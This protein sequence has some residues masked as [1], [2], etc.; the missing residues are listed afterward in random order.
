MKLVHATTGQIHFFPDP[1]NVRYVFFSHAW[2][3]PRDNEWPCYDSN[4]ALE[5]T[6]ISPSPSIVRNVLKLA[7]KHGFD[8]AWIDSLCIDKT[9]SAEISETIVSLS[10]YLENSDYC[11]A[12][13]AD[14]TASSVSPNV[15][16]LSRCKYWTRSW[17]LQ[18]MVV[19]SRVL[20]FD[21]QFQCIG[22][23]SSSQF[24]GL[25]SSITG[26]DEDVLCGRR[27]LQ[28]I[29]IARRMSWAAGRESSR[30]EDTI[31]ALLGLFDVLMPVMYGEGDT[32]AIRRLQQ[33][34]VKS[35]NDMSLLA[36]SSSEKGEFRGVFASS[37][38]EYH[39]FGTRDI[40]KFPFKFPG[41]VALTNCGLLAQGMM[42]PIDGGLFLNLGAQLG[43]E[44]QGRVIGLLLQQ[45]TDGKFMR[46]SDWMIKKLPMDQKLQP[47]QIMISCEEPATAATRVPHSKRLSNTSSMHHD[48]LNRGV[49]QQSRFP[50]L[51]AKGASESDILDVEMLIRQEQSIVPWTEDVLPL[52]TAHRGDSDWIDVGSDSEGSDVDLSSTVFS[53]I[54]LIADGC[55]PASRSSTPASVISTADFRLEDT[56]IDCGQSPVTLS[57]ASTKETSPDTSNHTLQPAQAK[58]RLSHGTQ[59]ADFEA[60]RQQLLQPALASFHSWSTIFLRLI[61]NQT[62]RVKQSPGSTRRLGKGRRRRPVNGG[63][64]LELSCPFFR[65]YPDRYRNCL[66]SHSL[67]SFSEV[68]DHVLE[69]HH[70]PYYCPTCKNTFELAIQ[71][72]EHIVGRTCN[73]RTGF[74]YVGVS[75]DQKMLMD[76]IQRYL[77][78]EEQWEQ[79]WQILFPGNKEHQ[80]P[81]LGQGLELK[82]ANMRAFWRSRGP[83]LVH[84]ELKGT[85]TIDALDGSQE[86]KLLL[87][88][89]LSDVIDNL[90]AGSSLDPSHTFAHPSA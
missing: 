44:S 89:I 73:L 12:Y 63:V 31:Y 80:S 7:Q 51:A 9:S 56:F 77:S 8:Y 46:S 33:E 10:S 3:S 41:F 40:A 58:M 39:D 48:Q 66:K 90:L 57:L 82:V 75:G 24:A 19:P 17:T 54:S 29:S 11:F 52:H 35:T 67:R 13:L 79:L 2:S 32:R 45:R 87:S 59:N 64:P 68:K 22:D 26:V 81:Y 42:S 4:G 61:G 27:A 62:R 71:R 83:A 38:Q 28:D 20:F 36:W 43:L 5:P 15:P 21:S 23:R 76:G 72:N 14:F 60:I 50:S 30:P 69:H 18:Q 65:R 37:L 1:N 53:K 16:S 49:P 84:T 88:Q 25:I 6:G 85:G 86:T 74:S 34:I 78:T 55:M 70:L 47:M